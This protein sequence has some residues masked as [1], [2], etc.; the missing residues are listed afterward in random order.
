MWLT[1][2]LVYSAVVCTL[3]GQGANAAI[4]APDF[5][6]TAS[7]ESI[8]KTAGIIAKD[9]MSFYTGDKPNDV[10]GNLPDPYY[11][12]EAGA[13]FGTMINYWHYTGD[14]Q[15]NAASMQ[16]LLH[17]K[18]DDNDYMPLNQSKTLGNDDQGFWGMAAMTA[19]E[20]N[21]P[22]P[23][24]DEPGWLAL[25]QGVF[26]TQTTRWDMKTCNG[27]L[28]WQIFPFNNGFNYKNTIS[29][30]CLFNLGARLAL[31]TGNAT[32]ADWATKTWD[33]VANVGFL[34]ADYHVYDGAQVA[35]NCSVRDHNTWSYN[36]GI[37]L[38]GAAAMYNFTDGSPLWEDR[39]KRLLNQTTNTF[40]VNGVMRE[41]CEA[42]K[43]NVDQ[44]SFKAYLARWMAATTNLA[45]FTEKPI[46]ALLASSAAAASSTC[47]GG[48]S[49][50]QC[51]LKW[52]TPGVNDGILGVGEQMAAL[53]IVQSNLIT[54]TPGWV[55]AVKGTGNSTGDPNAGSDSKGGVE[56]LMSR[57]I[58]TK[59][60]V[61]AGILTALVLIGVVGGS[62][63]MMISE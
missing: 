49:G 8:K 36:S 62:A 25:A 27:G 16:A 10:P 63:T 55:S 34:S 22:A 26:N 30:G 3:A 24:K 9:L 38:L 1:S 17:Q 11:W 44:Q 50:T 40:F 39:V 61:G 15:Y 46:L 37:Y 43:C 18:G 52:T 23:P 13:M 32:Y 29:N 33:W 56:A 6:S 45:P 51:G 4:T 31:Y 28:R 2:S 47:S 42:G 60:R 14:T 12:W 58:T 20:T 54:T 19:A 48:P 59:D 7:T 21:F 5:T 41:L 57:P 35:D 53:E